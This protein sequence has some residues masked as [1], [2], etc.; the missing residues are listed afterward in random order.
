MVFD[1]AFLVDIAP[2]ML[3]S[4]PDLAD[5]SEGFDVFYENVTFQFYD[6]DRIAQVTHLKS[7]MRSGGVLFCNEKL[8][9]RDQDAIQ[10]DLLF[11]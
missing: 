3:R 5:F 11:D 10:V 7:L 9:H 1:Q 2:E 8:L 4:R 6:D